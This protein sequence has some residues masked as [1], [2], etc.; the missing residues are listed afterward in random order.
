M[1]QLEFSLKLEHR[2]KYLKIKKYMNKDTQFNR[3]LFNCWEYCHTTLLYRVTLYS[4]RSGSDWLCQRWQI[5]E[6]G[7]FPL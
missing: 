4:D 6:V 3:I 5:K 2:T 7:G 1:T